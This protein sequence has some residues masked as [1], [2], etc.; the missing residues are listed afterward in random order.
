MVE[1]TPLCPGCI[2]LKALEWSHGHES[3]PRLIA[4]HFAFALTMIG[5]SRWRNCP[6]HALARVEET[7]TTRHYELVAGGAIKS[8]VNTW[9]A[10]LPLLEH[11][12]KPSSDGVTEVSLRIFNDLLTSCDV[13]A[14][15]EAVRHG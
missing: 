15:R 12:L 13:E 5:R 1:V 9:R 7:P 14:T 8:M 2:A 10:L 11:A 3:E 4:G 6:L